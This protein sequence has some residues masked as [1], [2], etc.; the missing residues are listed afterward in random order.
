MVATSNGRSITYNLTGAEQKCREL[1]PRNQNQ[2]VDTLRFNIR[3]TNDNL[4]SPDATVRITVRCKWA[5]PNVNDV[6]RETD[7]NTHLYWCLW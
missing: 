1:A 5:P 4:V 7:E 6:P 2:F 3:D